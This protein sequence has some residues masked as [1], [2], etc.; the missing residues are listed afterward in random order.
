M[1]SIIAKISN[2]QSLEISDYQLLCKGKPSQGNKLLQT[3]LQHYP[4]C[5][6]LAEVSH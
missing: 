5:I 4:D 6:P 3:N 1:H 2:I